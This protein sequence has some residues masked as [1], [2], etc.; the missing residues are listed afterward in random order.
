MLEEDVPIASQYRE[1]VAGSN[2]GHFKKQLD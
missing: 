2:N 1:G